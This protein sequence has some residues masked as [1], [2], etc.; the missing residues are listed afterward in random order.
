VNER[1]A[2]AGRSA[3]DRV[4]YH[5]GVVT[6][7]LDEGA[8][9]LAALSGVRWGPV[10]EALD[11]RLVDGDGPVGWTCRRR[12]DIGGPF[13]VEL[14]EGSGDSIWATDQV[15]QLHHLAYWSVD[16]NADVDGLVGAGWT[17]E[18]TLRGD[19]GRPSE[20]AYLAHPHEARIEL[21]AVERRGAYVAVHDEETT[22]GARS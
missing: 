2:I 21:V 14:L 13:H 18:A 4:P 10:A 3:L 19:D 16:V 9:A 20:F 1:V 12:H 5:L 8:A 6:R 7:D 11:P 17:L 15:L 22:V